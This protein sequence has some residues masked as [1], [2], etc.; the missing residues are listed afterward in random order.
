[1]AET[2]VHQRNSKMLTG[3]QYRF[4]LLDIEFM[5]I[6]LPTIVVCIF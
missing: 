3:S 1:M 6:P 2:L 5:K 4:Q